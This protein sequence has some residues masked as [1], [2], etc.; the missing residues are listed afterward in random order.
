MV[1]ADV[2]ILLIAI[3]GLAYVRVPV[4]VWTGVI[5]F[6]LL[7]ITL[8]GEML[9]SGLIFFWVIFLTIVIFSNFY[10]IR[11]HYLT[12]PLMRFLKKRIPTI[13][14]TEHEALEAGDVWWEK[15]LF[16]GR[17]EWQ[18]FL[19]HSFSQLSDEETHFLK[20][21]TETLCGML[22]DWEILHKNQ[23]LPKSV[24][25]YLKKERFLGMIIPKEYG[26]R[27]FSAA[28]HSM[29]VVKVATRSVSVAVNM[30]VPNSLGPAELLLHYG[31]AEQKEYYL[32]R[33]ARGDEIPCFALTSPEAGSDAGSITDS[34]IICKGQWDGKERLGIRL[35]WDKR[36]ITLAP[37]ATVLGLAFR[38]YDPQHLLGEEENRGITVCLIPTSHPGVEIGHRHL[39]LHLAFM[40]G[41]TR[42][43]DV[44]IP[45]EWILGGVSMAGHGWKMLMECL[46]TGRAI[47]LPALST[48]AA[49]SIYRETG[50]YARLRK[51]FGTAIANFEGVEAALAE[52]AGLTYL[53]ESCRWL[54]VSAVDHGIRPSTASAIAKYHMTE[55]S[56]K[57]VMH[58]MDIHGGHGIQMGPH[59]RLAQAH[60]ASPISIT[61][62][63]AN[64]LT[65][66]LIIFGQGAIRC[67]P[68]LL[69]EMEAITKNH[70]AEFDTLLLSHTGY[71]LSNFI[72]TFFYGL[73]GGKWILAPVRGKTACYYRQLTRMSM[74]LAVLSDI[75]VMVFGGNLKRKEAI[76]ARL[77]DILSG[78]Y[79]ASSVLKYA[80]H[81]TNSPTDLHYVKW[82][83]TTCLYH[84]QLACDE[85][86]H[87]FPSRWVG[88]IVRWFI[89]PWGR[90]YSKPQDDLSHQIVKS[91]LIPSDFRDRLT[92]GVYVSDDEKDP[93]R[94]I[95][96]AF[97]EIQQIDPIWKKFQS[98]VRSAI[99]PESGTFLKRT[100]IALKIGILN[101]Q[102]VKLLRDFYQLYSDV[103][104]VDEF[105]FNLGEI[106]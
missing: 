7:V 49:K 29:V 78:L 25:D 28:A 43:H 45:L 85:L 93:I 73:T 39:P 86:F 75:F 59:N 63:G 10:F 52:I 9:F 16:C 8:F 70:T 103:I 18:R 27:G 80:S 69:R 50:A 79:L 14:R 95:E 35:S 104:R 41:P 37:I 44:F 99:L 98:A 96:I 3:F 61:V 33:L 66:N 94:K 67:H 83:V 91:M 13:S 101:P 6:L 19:N 56:R 53:I 34:G 26:G 58:A 60:L 42:G 1:I 54:T 64:I 106:K 68:Y 20:T 72:R 47:S 84:I 97:T 51:Q 4:V 21:Q 12:R 31:T 22:N 23:D 2:F 38:L 87:N 74:T 90:A 81:H 55:M 102:E 24:W 89:F 77:G 15:D 65:R 76:S 40:N 32:P 17:P 57:I 82:C 62:E 71:I 30:M 88:K 46:S 100:E 36:Y 105:S 11:Q 5:G 48:A 92:S